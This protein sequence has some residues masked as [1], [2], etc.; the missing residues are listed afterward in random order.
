MINHIK[1]QLQRGKAVHKDT[2]QDVLLQD[3]NYI[4][5]NKSNTAAVNKT[6][7]RDW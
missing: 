5:T 3:Y 7:K 6:R 2:M 1:Q 4:V